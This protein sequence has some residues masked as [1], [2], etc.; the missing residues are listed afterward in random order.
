MRLILKIAGTFIAWIVLTLIGAA[1]MEITLG[2]R[3]PALLN[4]IVMILLIP[5]LFLM[6][7][8]RAGSKQ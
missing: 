1:A 7:R 3:R 6:W 8:P 4:L 2:E 5:V